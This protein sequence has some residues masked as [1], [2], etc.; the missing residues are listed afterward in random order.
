MNREL[1]IFEKH[2]CLFCG[3]PMEDHYEELEKYWECNCKDA[4]LDREITDKILS[5]ERS[6]PHKKYEIV[7]KQFVVSKNK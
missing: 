2:T 4:V 7:S 5:L 6:R 3:Q 1:G